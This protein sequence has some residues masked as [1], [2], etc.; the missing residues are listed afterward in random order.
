MISGTTVGGG[1]YPE[2]DG[3]EEGGGP[4]EGGA[5]IGVTGKRSGQTTA[6]R[7]KDGA[8]NYGT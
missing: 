8:L 3:D 7:R 4:P 1:G 6:R 5:R 2:G